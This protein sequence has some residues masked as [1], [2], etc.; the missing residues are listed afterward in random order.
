M[1]GSDPATGATACQRVWDRLPSGLQDDLRAAHALPEGQ[2]LPAYRTVRRDALTGQYGARVQQG[3]RLLRDRRAELRRDAPA[4][5]KA[6][7]RAARRLPASQRYD[8]LVAIHDR[9]L[10]GG[11]GRRVEDLAQA[12]QRFWQGC[13]GV[14]QGS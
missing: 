2:R 10:R 6:D 4:P 14:L 1:T 11:Y 9:A 3:A 7:V 8:A 13:S 12:R 5:L